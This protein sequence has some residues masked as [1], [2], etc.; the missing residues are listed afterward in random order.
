MISFFKSTLLLASLLLL[1]ACGPENRENVEGWSYGLI[2]PTLKNTSKQESTVV[3]K[4]IKFVVPKNT[5][6]SVSPYSNNQLTL[7]DYTETKNGLAN[8]SQSDENI[9]EYTPNQ[10][11]VGE[12]TFIAIALADNGEIV[13]LNVIIEVIE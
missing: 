13:E 9:I 7:V 6:L 11:Y 8:I 10:D 2:S 5:T 1:T 3:E 12:D 4:S